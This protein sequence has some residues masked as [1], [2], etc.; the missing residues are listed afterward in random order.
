MSEPL[1][2][3]C[4]FCG[5]G[6]D[7]GGFD[8]GSLLYTARWDRNES[9]QESQQFF[10]HTSCLSASFHPSTPVYILEDLG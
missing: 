7:R 2:F 8:I 9:Q 4:C 5:K 1:G 6:I 3:Q 10:C